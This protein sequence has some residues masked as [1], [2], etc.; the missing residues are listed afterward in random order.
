MKAMDGDDD[1]TVNLQDV[2]LRMAVVLAQFK[3]WATE[4]PGQKFFTP[5]FNPTSPLGAA[6][7]LEIRWAA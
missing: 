4:R 7:A 2:D 1:G 6:A 5:R 3:K